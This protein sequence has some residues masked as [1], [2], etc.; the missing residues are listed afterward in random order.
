MS[1]KTTFR[2]F[3]GINKDTGKKIVNPWVDS[4][5]R[6]HINKSEIGKHRLPPEKDPNTIHLP[7][8]TPEKM[9]GPKKHEFRPTSPMSNNNTKQKNPTTNATNNNTR[10]RPTFSPAGAGRPSG[11]GK[12]SGSFRRK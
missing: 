11:I 7:D 10:S 2:K 1:I 3:L 4:G 12:P 9:A 6:L 8:Q 5:I